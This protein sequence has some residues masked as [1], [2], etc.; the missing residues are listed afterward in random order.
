MTIHGSE[1]VEE[2]GVV[3]QSGGGAI[4]DGFDVEFCW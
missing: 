4:S 3:G 2:R 1:G